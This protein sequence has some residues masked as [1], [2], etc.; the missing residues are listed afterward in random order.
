MKITTYMKHQFSR[1]NKIDD[2]AAKIASCFFVM[3]TTVYPAFT[4]FGGYSNMVMKKTLFFW[5]VSGTIVVAMLILLA[6]ETGNDRISAC[7]I[8]K[9]RIYKPTIT[10]IA[11][12]LFIVCTLISAVL[13][14]INNPNW[15]NHR[16]NG[17]KVL[18]GENDRYEGLITFLYYAI[19]FVIVARFCTLQRFHL[20]LIAM[21]SIFVSLVGVLQLLG[22]D[23][24]RL[25]ASFI[26]QEYG[27]LSYIQRTTLGN[28]NLVSSYCSFTVLLFAAL[29]T[30]SH[31]KCQYLYLGTCMCSYALSFT[32]GFSGDA[33]KVAILGAMILL[34]PYWVS[35]RERLGKIII[36]LSGWCVIYAS[37]SAYMSNM[38]RQLETRV[39]FAPNDRLLLNTYTHKNIALHLIMAAA[40][41]C[42]GLVLLFLVKKWPKKLMRIV[43]TVL[44][45]I[46]LSGGLI[47]LE[48]IG[49]RLSDQP[50]NIIWQAREMMHGRLS[51]DFGSARGWVWRN[52]IEVIPD[53]PVFGT[54]PDTLFHALGMERQYESLER[55]GFG[56]DKAHNVFLQITVCMGIPALIAYVSFLCSL[57]IP[58]IKKA[59]EQ[60][61]VFAF[62]A[63]ALSYVIQSFFAIEVPI[64]TPLLWVSLGVMARELGKAEIDRKDVI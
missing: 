51:D 63:A 40:L 48:V 6:C 52:A 56:F 41:L 64:A 47:G 24:F 1:V 21:S 12:M 38:K 9:T 31:S 59:F 19:T 61:V 29:F 35:G 60:P 22:F 42:V 7:D 13:S 15:I 26:P 45:I 11:L 50:E 44:L 25:N 30:V 53:H 34:I 49:A 5:I 58:S 10:E 4:G 57:F 62:G 55:Y 27:P 39:D 43:G 23:V 14:F 32:T 20:S 16:F 36:V 28:V 3:I 37:Y 2:K 33:H 46:L 17:A 18:F 8:G 54:G